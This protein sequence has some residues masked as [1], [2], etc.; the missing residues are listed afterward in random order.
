MKTLKAKLRSTT[1]KELQE[2]HKEIQKE[3]PYYKFD[4][5]IQRALSDFLMMA[6]IPKLIEYLKEQKAKEEQQQ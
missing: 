4:D 2:A 5:L 6:K 1:Y 3:V